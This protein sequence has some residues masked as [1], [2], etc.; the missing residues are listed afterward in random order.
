MS[1]DLVQDEFVF[2]K[3]ALFTLDIDN[4]RYMEVVGMAGGEA[5]WST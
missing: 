4:E 1:F 5:E 3:D 2:Y